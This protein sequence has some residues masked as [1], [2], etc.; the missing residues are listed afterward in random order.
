MS[1]HILILIIILKYYCVN[2]VCRISRTN[3]FIATNGAVS[4]LHVLRNVNLRKL[5][6]AHQSYVKETRLFTGAKNGNASRFISVGHGGAL[7]EAITLN[8]RVVGSTPAL[9]AM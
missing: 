9:A 5:V 3:L 2:I 6:K 7:V 4:V 8:R 1:V